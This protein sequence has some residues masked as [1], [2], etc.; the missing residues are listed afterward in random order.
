[1]FTK[2]NVLLIVLLVLRHV[3]NDSK[4]DIDADIAGREPSEEVEQPAIGEQCD[5]GLEISSFGH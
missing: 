4:S 5:D 1:M 2:L 3:T